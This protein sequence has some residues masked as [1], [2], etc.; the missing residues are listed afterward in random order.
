MTTFA[1]VVCVTKAIDDVVAG[2]GVP[3][4]VGV[5][6]VA[7]VIFELDDVVSVAFADIDAV[8]EV[9]G[10]VVAIVVV[11]VVASVVKKF[12]VVAIELLLVVVTSVVV[13]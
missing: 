6:A 8:A 13:I 12:W 3:G 9:V 10:A 5:A 11:M 2:N 4:N 7:V 1:I